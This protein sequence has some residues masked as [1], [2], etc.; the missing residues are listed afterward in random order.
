MILDARAGIAS[1]RPRPWADTLLAKAGTL[2]KYGS[3]MSG[4]A[5]AMASTRPL[6]WLAEK[7]L[8]VSSKRQLPKLTSKTFT[9]WF[10]SD[11]PE[12]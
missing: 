6:R 4:V 3:S 11:Q 10:R 9:K 12:P 7:V 2:E 8:G 5:N 1:T